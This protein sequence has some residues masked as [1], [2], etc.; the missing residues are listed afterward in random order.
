MA[1]EIDQYQLEK[2]Y[3]RKDAKVV[4][5][6]VSVRLVRDLQGNPLHFLPMMEDITE[7]KHAEEALRERE[8][9]YRSLFENSLDGIFV[10]DPVSGRIFSA[11]P[12]ACRMFGGAEEDVC[13]LGRSGVIDMAD[14]GVHDFIAEH[15][16]SGKATGEI[17]CKRCD[18]STFACE[19]TA[20]VF[21]GRDGRMR[22][23]IVVARHL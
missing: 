6:S 23:V 9:L 10:T 1:G 14:P 11:N 3:L 18:G 8:D 4:W 16:R 22:S 2:R 5:V 21:A 17:R 7:R 12:A 20:A 13:A 15:A 19:Q